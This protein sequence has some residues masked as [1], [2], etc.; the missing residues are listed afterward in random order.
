M[1]VSRMPHVE[2][3]KTQRGLQ[4]IDQQLPGA[5]TLEPPEFIRVND[6]DS[7]STMQRYMLRTF[8]VCET[9]Q[10]AEARLSV[11]EAPSAMGRLS[12]I[13]CASCR[14]SSHADQITIIAR[15]YF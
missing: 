8:A 10:F 4:R 7:I 11:L 13:L 9:H 3:R 2:V 15:L 5:F 12:G 1:S 6:D 14:L